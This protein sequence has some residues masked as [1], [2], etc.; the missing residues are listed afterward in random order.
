M[1]TFITYAK[2]LAYVRD[3]VQRFYG[4]CQTL[5]IAH[6]QLH[7]YNNRQRKFKQALEKPYTGLELST[8]LK[9]DISCKSSQNPKITKSL[10]ANVCF[11][12]LQLSSVLHKKNSGPTNCTTEQSAVLLN[13]IDHSIDDQ[14]S[15]DAINVLINGPGGEFF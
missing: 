13:N 6:S 4:N 10:T 15:E 1:P 5:Y 12:V 3:H 14:I 11:L 2:I 9:G 7:P 8:P